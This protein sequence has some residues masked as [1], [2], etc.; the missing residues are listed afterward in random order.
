[1]NIS[2]ANNSNVLVDI[3]TSSLQSKLS[4]TNKLSSDFIIGLT[5]LNL[6]NGGT[7][8]GASILYNNTIENLS[9]V[10]GN[11]TFD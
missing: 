5:H 7:A 8:N 9:L 3:D 2:E 6:I 4:T 11:T 10:S 1:M